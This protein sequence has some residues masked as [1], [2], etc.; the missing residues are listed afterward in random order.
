LTVKL[1]GS[2]IEQLAKAHIKLFIQ[3]FNEFNL[4]AEEKLELIRL[5]ADWAELDYCEGLI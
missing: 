3:Q 5:V 1:D 2:V 4:T